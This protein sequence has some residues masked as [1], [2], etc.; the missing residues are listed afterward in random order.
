MIKDSRK[1]VDDLGGII[2]G[3]SPNYYYKRR[4]IRIEIFGAIS[5]GGV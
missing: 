2:Y 5:I 3:I 4:H 1:S